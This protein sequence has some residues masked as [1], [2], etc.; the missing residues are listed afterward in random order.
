MLKKWQ[1]P[2]SKKFIKITFFSSACIIIS[3]FDLHTVHLKCFCS[4]MCPLNVLQTYIKN[5]NR[6]LFPGGQHTDGQIDGKPTPYVSPP[7]RGETIM[8]QHPLVTQFVLTGECHNHVMLHCML[9]KITYRMSNHKYIYPPPP[10]S[11][12]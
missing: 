6:K 4:F 1:S 11:T 10:L 2:N 5:F 3:M 9:I 8:H 7:L 12:F